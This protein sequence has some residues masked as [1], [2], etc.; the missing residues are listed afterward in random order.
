MLITKPWGSKDGKDTSLVYMTWFSCPICSVSIIII[1]VIIAAAVVVVASLGLHLQNV[2]V[3]RL[4]VESEL[5][6]PAHAT[7]TAMQDPSH[8]C[9]LHHSSQQCQILN[10][11]SEARDWIHILMDP[12]W[13]C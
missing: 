5:Q 11:L 9:N 13:V 7:A 4:G 10:P 8:I 6:L 1:I 2:E 3:P 12:S